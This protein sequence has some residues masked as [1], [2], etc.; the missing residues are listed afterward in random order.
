MA[1]FESTPTLHT[2]VVDNFYVGTVFV[3]ENKTALDSAVRKTLSRITTEK[4][5]NT[6]TTQRLFIRNTITETR[7]MV[8]STK[9]FIT[10]SLTETRLSFEETKRF[11]SRILNETR[12]NIDI[13]KRYITK[14]TLTDTVNHVDSNLRRFITRPMSDTRLSS[15]SY[16]R[17]VS[18]ITTENRLNTEITK[19]Y[20][21]RIT[22]ETA[23]HLDAAKRFFTR[24]TTETRIGTESLRRTLTRRLDEVRK[25]TDI[26]KRYIIKAILTDTR[27]VWDIA[28]LRFFTRKTT[29]TRVSAEDLRRT[30]SRSLTDVRIIHDSAI[31]TRTRLDFD[32]YAADKQILERFG[33]KWMK[34]PYAAAIL[35]IIN[36]GSQNDFET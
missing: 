8:E 31:A 33:W 28:A 27:D 18:R 26:T 16:W 1:D 21:S 23:R 10:K 2:I 32:G 22:S 12:L 35:Q 13:V 9:R 11:L 17:Y 5:L 14:A 19:R 15:I 29:E 30:L 3:R 4:L 36:R 24:L 20:I 6:D 7:Q 34:E 25:N